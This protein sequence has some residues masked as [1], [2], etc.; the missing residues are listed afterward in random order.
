VHWTEAGIEFMTSRDGA[1]NA[2]SLRGKER[3]PFVAGGELQKL[4]VH[5]ITVVHVP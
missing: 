5:A 2:D 4:V 3:V 1:G